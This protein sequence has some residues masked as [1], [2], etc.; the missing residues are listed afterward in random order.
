MVYKNLNI[1]IKKK[2][3]NSKTL[4]HKGY[5][6]KQKERKKQRNKLIIS[7]P[8]GASSKKFYSNYQ[9]LIGFSLKYSIKNA[10]ILNNKTDFYLIGIDF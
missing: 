4:R 9:Y 6:E 1:K 5:G 10:I 7:T 3:N 2:K 8:K